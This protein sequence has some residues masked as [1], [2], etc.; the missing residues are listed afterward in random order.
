MVLSGLTLRS[1]HS[2]KIWLAVESHGE[3][4]VPCLVVVLME[5]CTGCNGGTKEVHVT[6]SRAF[7]VEFKSFYLALHDLVS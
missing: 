4:V 1:V 5:V 2:S 3:G 7:R 6:F